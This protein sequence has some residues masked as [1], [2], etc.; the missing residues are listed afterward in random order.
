MPLASLGSYFCLIY[1]LELE[2]RETNCQPEEYFLAN[3]PLDIL[4]KISELNYQKESIQL[5]YFDQETTNM[6]KDITEKKQLKLL[7]RKLGV[8]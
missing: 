8:F 1:N 4:E 5:T 7:V 3:F 2:L 6:I